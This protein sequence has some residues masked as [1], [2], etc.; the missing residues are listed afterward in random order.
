MKITMIQPLNVQ[1]LA[2]LQQGQA[3]D[4]GDLFEDPETLN[5][6]SWVQS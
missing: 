5:S 3:I 2:A 4:E 6:I 1:E